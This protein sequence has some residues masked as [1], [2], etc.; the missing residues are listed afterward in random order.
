MFSL[1]QTTGYTVMALGCLE[2]IGGRWVLAKDVAQS[3]GIPLP[4]LSKILHALSQTGLVRSK[5]GYRGGFALARPA[6]QISLLDIAEAVE[7]PEWLPQCLLGLTN[8]SKHQSC[9]THQFWQEERQ[10]IRQELGRITLQDVVKFQAD[11][12]ATPGG[13]P[14]SMCLSTSIHQARAAATG[15]LAQPT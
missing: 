15:T 3:T 10:R 9:P 4:Y 1:S 13:K 8:C 11:M 2:G 5:R 14:A 6:D 12:K 7:G